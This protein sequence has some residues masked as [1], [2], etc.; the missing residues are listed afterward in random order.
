MLQ[1]ENTNMSKLV[2]TYWTT[3]SEGVEYLK[4]D[5]SEVLNDK[6]AIEITKEAYKISMNRADKSIRALTIVRNGKLSPNAMRKI[7]KI[8]AKAQP[9]VYRSAVVGKMGVLPLLLNIY[10]L[11]T[12]S[13]I[14]FFTEE[15]AAL[16]YILID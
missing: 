14:R 11:Y 16:D 6:E 3:S 12:G 13:K 15:S 2:R 1:L 10:V 8:G 9:K 7:T 4:L 5:Y